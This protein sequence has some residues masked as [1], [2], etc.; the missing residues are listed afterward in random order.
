MNSIVKKAYEINERA[1]D[2]DINIPDL[3]IGDVVEL[4]EVW[5]CEEPW[6]EHDWTEH[7]QGFYSYIVSHW[8]DDGNSK[9]DIY[10]N[11]VFDILQ[12]DEDTELSNLVKIVDIEL[13]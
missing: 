3:E 4:R 6:T 8:G 5:D 10:I 11:Y 13:I 2:W 7:P 9:Y 1:E 12:I